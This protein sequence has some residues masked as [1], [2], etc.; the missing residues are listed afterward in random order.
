MKRT[1]LLVELKGLSA[2]QLKERASKVAEELLKLRF[3]HGSGQLEQT[4]RLG[5]LKR[6]LARVKTILTS[7]AKQA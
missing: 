6:E 7:Q 2:E 5:E 3:R 1:D 4:S